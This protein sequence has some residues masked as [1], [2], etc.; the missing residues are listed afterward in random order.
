METVQATVDLI[1]FVM[2]AVVYR[3]LGESTP[4]LNRAVLNKYFGRIVKYSTTENRKQMESK[5]CTV[6]MTSIVIA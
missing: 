2:R 1:T 3:I 5:S 4:E 6:F